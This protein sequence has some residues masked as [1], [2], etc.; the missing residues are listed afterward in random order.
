MNLNVENLK[1]IP[2]ELSGV[3]MNTEDHSGSTSVTYYGCVHGALRRIMG[4]IGE[5]PYRFPLE[6]GGYPFMQLGLHENYDLNSK[7]TI[8][9]ATELLRGDPCYV[10]PKLLARRMAEYIWSIQDP[11]HASNLGQIESLPRHSFKNDFY[12]GTF[13]AGLQ[14][15]QISIKHIT[16]EEKQK[17]LSEAVELGL[18]QIKDGRPVYINEQLTGALQVLK[19]EI[20]R[21]RSEYIEYLQTL[22]GPIV[23]ANVLKVVKEFSIQMEQPLKILQDSVHQMETN[24]VIRDL[25]AQIPSWTV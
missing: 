13:Y 15:I 9:F 12:F 8:N 3:T 6:A 1:L 25:Y 10:S 18:Y 11:S 7:Q 2:H 24:L 19:P 23:W 16:P 20:D 5:K 21:R 17:Y 4:E 14:A 22:D